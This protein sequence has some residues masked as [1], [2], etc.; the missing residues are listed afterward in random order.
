VAGSRAVLV[1]VLGHAAE[2]VDDPELLAVP[3]EGVDVFV[4]TKQADGKRLAELAETPEA[5]GIFLRRIVRGATAT[6]IPILP[7]RCIAA[8]S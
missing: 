5:R 1:E 2:E 4:S 6:V 3:A 7:Q 8:T